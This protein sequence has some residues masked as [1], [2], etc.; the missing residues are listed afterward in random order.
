MKKAAS[1]CFLSAILLWGCEDAPHFADFPIEEFGE[2]SSPESFDLSIKDSPID[3]KGANARF[4]ADVA[5]GRFGLNAFDIWMPESEVPT[6]LVLFFHGGGFTKGDKSKVYKHD[7]EIG[8]GIEQIQTLVQNN[9]AFATVNYRL[10]YEGDKQGV[11]RPLNDAKYALQFIR[12]HHKD[13]NIDPA[14]IALTGV[15]AGA[16]ACLWVGLSDDMADSTHT[17]PVLRES[18]RVKGLALFAT[19]S[20]YDA[21]KWN[22]EVL[23]PE[24]TDISGNAKEQFNKSLLRFY[25]IESIEELET[26]ELKEYCKKVEML[27]FISPDDPP[28]YIFNKQDFEPAWPWHTIP[29]IYHSPYHSVALRKNLIE[30]NV[31]HEVFIVA[32]DGKKPGKGQMPEDFLIKVLNQ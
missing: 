28:V 14:R 11:I 21:N 6:P 9:V 25:G 10:L 22:E 1:I 24:I 8:I 30:Q 23:P 31:P 5:Y 18:T 27:S 17:D 12:H 13:L 2:I 29:N 4:A 16:G 3:L 20:T 15:S 7:T 26:E 19:Q 32:E